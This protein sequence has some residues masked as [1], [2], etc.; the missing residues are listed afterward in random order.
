M[1][2]DHG[3]LGDLGLLDTLWYNQDVV[4]PNMREVSRTIGVV[5]IEEVAYEAFSVYDHLVSLALSA[6]RFF[7]TPLS[8][9]Q[10]EKVEG[11]FAPLKAPS[12]AL[13]LL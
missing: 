4:A 8:H 12:D 7:V 6:S 10:P 5:F 1:K 11:V 13:D 3:W 2:K 9:L